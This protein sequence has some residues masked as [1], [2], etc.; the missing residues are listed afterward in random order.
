M[1]SGAAPPVAAPFLCCCL[2]GSPVKVPPC[3]SISPLF[4]CLVV[5]S[6]IYKHFRPRPSL[7]NLP[8]CACSLES[9][10]SAENGVGM[11][12]GAIMTSGGGAFKRPSDDS[13][14]PRSDE[15]GPS[16]SSAL[17]RRLM[18]PFLSPKVK[19]TSP[20]VRMSW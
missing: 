1:L 8:H 6:F 11:I 14:P 17:L 19:I 5:L 10:G 9:R 16:P 2:F 12:T 15:S 4:R 7:H 3:K 18:P 13:A 20:S